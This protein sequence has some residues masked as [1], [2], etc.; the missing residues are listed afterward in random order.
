MMKRYLTLATLFA[1][2]LTNST[3]ASKAESWPSW[4]GREGT[5]PALS[6]MSPPNGIPPMRFGRSNFP[7]KGTPHR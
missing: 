4:R 7:A 6:K 2:L 5:A 1:G 3:T